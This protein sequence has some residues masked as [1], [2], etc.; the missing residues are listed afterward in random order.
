MTNNN[1]AGWLIVAA[2]ILAVGFILEGSE[3]RLPDLQ[4]LLPKFQL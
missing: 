3:K 4:I 1:K 2:S